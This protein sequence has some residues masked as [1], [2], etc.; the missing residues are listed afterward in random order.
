M[1]WSAADRIANAGVDRQVEIRA[2]RIE[3]IATA[4]SQFIATLPPAMLAHD[5]ARIE[6][7]TEAHPGPHC[8]GRAAYVNPISVPDSAYCGRRGIQLDLRIQCALAQARQRTMLGLTKKTGFRARQDQREGRSQVRASDRAHGWFD[9]IRHRRIAV[10]KEGFRPEFDFP[11]RRREAPRVSL[12]IA[13]SVL[14]VLRRQRLPYSSRLRPKLLQGDAAGT[15]LLPVS[16]VDTA[17]PEML[18]KTE[19]RGKTQDNIGIGAGLAGRR[20]D[21]LPK[22]NARLRLWTDFE[23]DLESF[24]FEAGRHRQHDIRKRRRRRHEQIGMG[25]EI[26]PGQ[27]STSANRIAVSEQQ[28][29]AEPDEAAG[30]IARAFQDGAGQ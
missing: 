29:R 3:R 13:R 7:F 11:R 21:G 26:E 1:G 9:K 17:V 4:N 6:L 27:R 16:G 5:D 28:I 12:V 30:G 23:S 25:V 18:A 14:D 8:A 24:A 10:I 15:K 22:L 20:D 19:T 2:V